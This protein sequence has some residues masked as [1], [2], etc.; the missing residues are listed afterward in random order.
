MNVKREYIILAVL[1]VLLSAYLVLKKQNRS[2]YELPDIPSLSREDITKIEISKKDHH[3]TLT[4]KDTKWR[5]EPEGYLADTDKV[6]GM[7]DVIDKLNLTALVSESK[8]YDIYDLGD[9]KK[10]TVKAWGSDG[11]LKRE[12][13]IG[14]PAESYRHTHVKL[15]NDF[16]VYHASTN[17]RPKFDQTME[18]LRD[19]N[20][21]SF[22]KTHIHRITYVLHGKTYTFEKK[23][24]EKTDQATAPTEK[25]KTIQ[26]VESEW[27]YIGKGVVDQKRLENLLDITSKL[28]CET[29]IYDRQK[30]DFRHP[31]LTLIFKGD[32][33]YVLNVYGKQNPD[34]KN[35]PCV[36]SESAQPFEIPDYQATVFMESLLKK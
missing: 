17:F 20:V 25:E 1:I 9:D 22:D 35:R 6:S 11:T 15:P 27:K 31:D 4:K 23:Q 3:I 18:E 36:S 19:K 7:L 28:K 33:E 12:F 2:F 21:L 14:K 34:D 30:R 24:S 29:Y 13:D 10:I 26:P 16:R 5:I 8:N 32:R